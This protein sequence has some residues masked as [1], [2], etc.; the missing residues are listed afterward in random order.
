MEIPKAIGFDLFNTLITV[1][2]KILALAFERLIKTLRRTGFQIQEESFKEA[3]RRQ[4]KRFLEATRATGRETHNRFW[5]AGALGE[6]GFHVEPDDPRVLE[7]VE[8]YFKAFANKCQLLPGTLET[9]DR[10]KERYPLGLLSNFTHAPAA[11]SILEE[12]GLR[13]IFRVILISGDLGYRKPHPCVFRRLCDE[14]GVLPGELLYVGDD[15]GPDIYGALD[16]GVRPV[17]S[18]HAQSLGVRH[19][20][21]LAYEGLPSPDGK[22][23]RISRWEELLALV[24]MNRRQA[25]KRVNR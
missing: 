20:A 10:L 3:Y 2:P 8:D 21:D 22:I 17:W 12:L 11:W 14:L 6:A 4:A 15:P 1:D 9:L 19:V 16:A 13:S 7:A 18:L 25:A 5:V 23:P 24:G